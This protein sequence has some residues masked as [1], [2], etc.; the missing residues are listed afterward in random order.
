MPYTYKITNTITQE[1]YFGSRYVVDEPET[2]LWIKYFTSSSAVKSL[3]RQY[4]KDS[5]IIE[6]V[7]I[8]FDKD[9]CFWDEQGLIKESI[10]DPLCLNRQYVNNGGVAFI[11]TGHSDATRIKISKSK[12]GK[13]RSKFDKDQKQKWSLN[14]RISMMN[15]S[16]IEKKLHTYKEINHQ[17]GCKNS[18]FGS[19]WISH[20]EL[21]SKKCNGDSLNEYL[22]NGWVI[23]RKLISL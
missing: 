5:F 11:N 13:D 10:T 16:S 21:G 8:Y 12:V 19:R 18:Q 20:P 17:Q 1:F 23:G 4:G 22:S 15:E 6:V 9:K 14:G 3:I 7:N 2:D